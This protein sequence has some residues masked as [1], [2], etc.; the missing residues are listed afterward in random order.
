MISFVLGKC[1]IQIG[2]SFFALLAFS[3]LFVGAGSSAF[4]LG[5]AGIHELAHLVV[6]CGLGVPPEQIRLTLWGC[7]M[8]PNRERRLG[9][10][11]QAAISL[12]GPGIN[13]LGAGFLYAVGLREHP[14]FSANLVLG[15]LH[16]LPIEPLDGGIALHALL[17]ARWKEHVAGWISLGISLALLFPL[18]VLGFLLL[19]QTRYN[20][21]LLALSI[22]LMLYLLLREDLF[23]S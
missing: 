8:V 11:S 13:L 7:R 15:I 12:A 9:F 14:F 19:L 6:L 20:F 3:C 17:C 18:G 4:F 1:R 10:H 22:Y 16:I 5:A 21:T 2:F 23:T